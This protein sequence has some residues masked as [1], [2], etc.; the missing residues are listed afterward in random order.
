MTMRTVIARG[1]VPALALGLC[2]CGTPETQC[3]DG[4]K[5]M[6]QRT[7]TLVGFDQP[8]DVKK[9]L[10][11]VSTAESQLATGNFEG[12]VETLGQARAHLRSSQRTN[13]Q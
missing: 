12:C 4:V 10:E 8:A 5:E 1:I 3:R 6:K 11:E 7:A 13:T 2:A 9:A